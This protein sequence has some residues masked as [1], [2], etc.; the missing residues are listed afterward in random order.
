MIPSQKRVILRFR[1]LAV[2][3][4]AGNESFIAAH[5][6]HT[7]ERDGD[8]WVVYSDD[9]GVIAGP[10]DF[11]VSH[12]AGFPLVQDNFELIATTYHSSFLSPEGEEAPR[13]EF[14][15]HLTLAKNLGLQGDLINAFELAFYTQATAE[16]S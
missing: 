12:D 4:F 13:D 9:P 1:G 2:P 10:P 15:K 5:T 3:Q 14:P 8:D 7:L 11:V 6:G 16:R